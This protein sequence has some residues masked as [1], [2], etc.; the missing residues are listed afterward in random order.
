MSK[1]EWC[2]YTWN[3][4][5]GCTK[6][7][8][9]CQNCYAETLGRRFGV[10]WGPS[11]IR[12]ESSEATWKLP[13]R[14]NKKPRMCDACGQRYYNDRPI[15]AT[16]SDCDGKTRPA[17]VFSLSMGDWLEG[18]PLDW[19]YG[20]QGGPPGQPYPVGGVPVEWL[21]RLLDTIRQT[22][23]LHWIL[24]TKRPE[25]FFR[26]CDD[27]LYHLGANADFGPMLRFVVDWKSGDP[28]PNVCVM[29]SIENQEMADER[30]PHLLS[31][32]ARWHGVSAEP[33]LGPIDL[34]LDKIGLQEPGRFWCVTGGESG[35]GARPCGVE[36]IR[37]LVRQ[38]SKAGVAVFVKAIGA[39]VVGSCEDADHAKNRI[40]F[41]DMTRIYFRDRKAGDPSEWPE[42]LR[43]RQWP[44]G[45]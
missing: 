31:I 3:P 42:D 2:D 30:I 34:R 13:L 35:L 1:I 10:G 45:L 39:H 18:E 26:G 24:V 41:E 27:V 11:A 38:G 6:V 19:S 29:A 25:N 17:R 37:S 7:S 44:E 40:T 22:P 32:P 9:G 14:W 15:T 5:R 43:V 28:P 33:L 20:K 36:W 16:C 21:A 12:V 4:W 8:A 23:D